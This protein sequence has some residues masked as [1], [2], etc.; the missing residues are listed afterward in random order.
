MSSANMTN[1]KHHIDNILIRVLT[2]DAISRQDTASRADLPSL[3]R[4]PMAK[5]RVGTFPTI[6]HVRRGLGPRRRQLH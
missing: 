1:R 2:T 3:G 5:A 6:Q 4:Q